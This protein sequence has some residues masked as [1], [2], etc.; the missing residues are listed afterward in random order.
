[1]GFGGL[2]GCVASSRRALGLV[3]VV[4][5]VGPGAGFLLSSVSAAASQQ[6][7][8]GVKGGRLVMRGGPG[9]EVL[10]GGPGND[11]IYGGRGDD[12]IYGGPGNDVIYGGPGNDVIYGGRGNDRIY[13]GPGNDVIYGGAGKD[14]IYGGPGN[15]RIIAVGGAT[16]V[17]PGSGTNSVDV[18]DGQG[19]DRVVC[20]AD[21]INH[22]TADR[23]DRIAG[24]C[25]G[26]GS[27]LSYGDS[28]LSGPWMH[29]LENQLW[30]RKL[31]DIVIPGSHDTGTYALPDDPISLIGKAQ[32]E[33]IT[34]QLDDGIRSFDIRV[35]WS[36]GAGTIAEPCYSA[37]YYARHGALTACSLTM[38]DIF[39]QI[40][41]W[42]NLPGNQQEI[43]L[44]SLSIDN[45]GADNYADTLG[46]DCEAFGKALGS[47]LLTPG[48]LE[49]AGY[50]A[51]PGQVTLGQLWAM[52]GHPRVLVT[53][54]LCMDLAEGAATGNWPENPPTWNPDPPFGSGAGQSYYANQCYASPY[55]EY[56]W[57]GT[58]VFTMPGIESQVEGAAET[59]AIQGGGDDFYPGDAEQPGLPMQ[60][61]LWTLFLQATPTWACAKSLADFDPAAQKQV[62]ADLYRDYWND[63]NLQANINILAGDFVH[64]SDL[65]IDAGAIDES[66][67]EVPGAITAV[68]AQTVVQPS[69]SYNLPAT[70]FAAGLTDYAG[71]AMPGAQVTYQVSPAPIHSGVGWGLKKRE[72]TRTVTADA[73]GEVNPGD[74]L[75]L[76]ES[77]PGT[78][79]VTVSAAGGVKATW[80]VELKAPTGTH[81]KALT[82]P[83]S[84]P[85]S[86]TYFQT[87]PNGY[88][89]ASFAVEVDNPQGIPVPGIPVTFD[90]GSAGVWVDGNIFRKSVVETTSGLGAF[91]VNARAPQFLT[92]SQAGNFSISASAP[93]A[94]NTLSLPIT[95][96]SGLTLT[97][98]PAAFV[99]TQGG[100]Q[101]TPINTKVPIALKG[102]YVDQYGNPVVPPPGPVTLSLNESDGTW[103]N[104]KTSVQVK[105]NADGTITAPDLTAGNTVLNNPPNREL[106]VIISSGPSGVSYATA[107]QEEVTPGPAAKVAA[108]SDASQQT[109]ARKPFAGALAVKVTDV[110]GNPI[111][112]APVTF[113]V[114]SGKA[115]FPPANLQLAAAVTGRPALLHLA[116]PPR[117][118][119]TVATND[120]GVA[121]A[122]ALTAGATVG[123]IEV[124]ASVG[125]SGKLKAVFHPSVVS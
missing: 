113:K 84:A 87:L 112:G 23:G 101:S 57:I 27:A 83:C 108:I 58:Q 97:S 34:S 111:A 37:D 49:A 29:D 75:D 102:H 36:E 50:S 100:G 123:P 4:L 59:R 92:G 39:N 35:R 65:V 89:Q 69:D 19:N 43:I 96:T 72:A 8:A 46:P 120:Q 93:G 15:D 17:F 73:Q 14:A 122:P 90:A 7:Q 106:R 60:G 20:A 30:S 24:N 40:A 77:G 124:T 21:S 31:S 94:D 68:G 85:V 11:V 9:N 119:V 63:P 6:K 105:P 66:Y 116:N 86:T 117:D 53:D 16:T 121:T 26:K 32:N 51:D 47:A 18:A 67:P 76:G 44:V 33:D 12:R 118:A 74:D 5:V 109:I 54:E 80:T 45:S 103:P 95:L 52:P 70:D 98:G 48:Q 56:N 114:T 55:T 82:C 91:D 42:T 64:D 125:V 88:E 1:M 2:W 61:G 99:A 28:G 13:G 78:W 107:W 79:T 71:A 25:L 110:R 22:I 38:S 104:G 10:R 3:V 41:T 115:A 81:L 62:L